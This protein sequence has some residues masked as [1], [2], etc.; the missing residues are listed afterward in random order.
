VGENLLIGTHSHGYLKLT[1][2]S[3][4]DD[5]ADL[6]RPDNNGQKWNMKWI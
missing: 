3:V 5:D 4:E 1:A 6:W 2:G